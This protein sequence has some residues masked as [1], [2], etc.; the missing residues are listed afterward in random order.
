MQCGVL[1]A[2]SLKKEDFSGALSELF[3]LGGGHIGWGPLCPAPYHTHTCAYTY[4]HRMC[5][6][7]GVIE[8]QEIRKIVRGGGGG[9]NWGS[10]LFYVS[11]LAPEGFAGSSGNCVLRDTHGVSQGSSF[12]L[13]P[14]LSEVGSALLVHKLNN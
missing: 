5:R 7:C 14:A 12:R 9:T 13:D 3:L 11:P 2:F 8:L 10:L 4:T 6:D 1:S